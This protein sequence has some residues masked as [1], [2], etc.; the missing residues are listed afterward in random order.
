MLLDFLYKFFLKYFEILSRTVEIYDKCIQI[1]KY[2][3]GM[4]LRL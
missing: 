1:F 3:S 2:I 4:L